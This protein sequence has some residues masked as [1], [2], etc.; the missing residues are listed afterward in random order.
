MNRRWM[1]K[2]SRI[3]NGLCQCWSSFRRNV[4]KQLRI[5]LF[6]NGS[7]SKRNDFLLGFTV[8][9][10]KHFYKIHIYISH[11]VIHFINLPYFI[12]SFYPY[13]T[14]QRLKSQIFSQIGGFCRLLI[15][16]CVSRMGIFITNICSLYILNHNSLFVKR[17]LLNFLLSG[18]MVCAFHLCVTQSSVWQR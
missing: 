6:L 8:K 14:I 1:L 4:G 13:I 10:V 11:V 18:L 7:S 16:F 2:K 5:W 17:F 9:A 12:G 15:F 3:V